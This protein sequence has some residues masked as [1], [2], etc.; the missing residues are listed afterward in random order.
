M[1]TFTNTMEIISVIKIKPYDM[2][3]I[4]REVCN[5]IERKHYA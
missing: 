5:C 1:C 3:K 4:V 2:G